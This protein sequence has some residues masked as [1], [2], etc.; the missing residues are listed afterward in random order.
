ML[1]L[2]MA[3]SLLGSC[4]YAVDGPVVARTDTETLNINQPIADTLWATGFD[5]PVGPPN[6]K[7]YYNAQGF[8]ENTHL[9]DDWNGNG[10]GNTDLGDTVYAIANGYVSQAED[11]KGGWGKVLRLVHYL[12][13]GHA[14]APAVESL[15]AHLDEM[16]VA[17]G[18]WVTKGMPIGT[19]GNAHGKYYAHLHL[20]LRNQPGLDLGGGYSTDTTGYIN[21]DWFIRKYR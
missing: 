3:I 4:T 1:R 2:L 15:Y 7:G 13:S 18:T 5:F 6:G 8:G 21:P 14:F 9:G 16:F 20:E 11:L 12:P 17:E 10:G 19:I